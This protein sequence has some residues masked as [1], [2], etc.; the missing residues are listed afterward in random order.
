M[1]CKLL[2]LFALNTAG[3]NL[4]LWT[5]VVPEKGARLNFLKQK[6]TGRNTAY[7]I[8]IIR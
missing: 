1:G 8:L 2:M 3:G 4:K 5:S 7:H 6:Y